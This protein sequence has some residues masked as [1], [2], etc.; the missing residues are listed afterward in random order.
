MVGDGVMTAV[1]V[2][3]VFSLL[4]PA[5]I[6]VKLDLVVLPSIFL[7]A[8]F[9]ARADGILLSMIAVGEGVTKSED[10]ASAGGVSCGKTPK[11]GVKGLLDDAVAPSKFLPTFDLAC[12]LFGAVTEDFTVS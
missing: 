1:D 12:S 11:F 4:G 2:F 5:I 7:G 10:N 9:L 8:C 3:V 6:P